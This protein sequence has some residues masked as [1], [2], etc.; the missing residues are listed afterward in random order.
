MS[1]CWTM[2]LNRS[3][4]PSGSRGTRTHKRVLLAAC[5]Q[6]VSGYSSSP[7][8]SLSVGGEPCFQ[9]DD[10]HKLLVAGVGIEPTPPGS[11]PSIATS[12]DHL[13]IKRE[14]LTQYVRQSS[15]SRV[16]TRVA[17][18]KGRQPTVSR[19]PIKSALRE[20]NPPVQLGRLMPLPI[21]QGHVSH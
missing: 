8:S 1:Y 16:R 10:F 3:T 6:A 20:S 13:A 21:G 5:F 17:R 12:S 9:P 19:S 2:S 18:A 7:S 11:E 14:T 15:G 4:T